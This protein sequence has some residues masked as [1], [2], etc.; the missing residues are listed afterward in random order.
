MNLCFW[1][2]ARFLLSPLARFSKPFEC[3]VYKWRTIAY[4]KSSVFVWLPS[5]ISSST[6][7]KELRKVSAEQKKFL[8]FIILSLHWI[9]STNLLSVWFTSEGLLRTTKAASLFDCLQKS[10][11]LL[12]RKNW[13][14]WELSRKSL[15]SS[16][17]VAYHCK[18]Q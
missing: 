2:Y 15:S 3:V 6:A 11:H 18:Y 16:S 8:I 17:F 14:K 10:P 12:L 9:D 4:Y 5:K 13:E 7:A 1:I